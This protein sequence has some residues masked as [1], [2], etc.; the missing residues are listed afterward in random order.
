MIDFLN[1]M[2]VMVLT[3]I[4]EAIEHSCNTFFYQ[5]ILNIGLDRWAKYCR[6]FGFGSTDWF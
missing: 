3:N 6:M 4:V 2:V 1:V 5:L